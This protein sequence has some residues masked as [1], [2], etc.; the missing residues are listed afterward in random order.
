M[1]SIESSTDVIEPTVSTDLL[2]YSPGDTAVI[3]AE[4]FI[5]GST[6]E[7]QVLHVL[8]PG[9]DGI[10]G[11]S[12]DIIDEETNASGDGHETWTVTDG[13]RTAGE[14]GILGTRDDGGDLDGVADGN[15]TTTWYVNPDDSLDATFLLSA[16]GSGSDGIL[17][18]EDDQLATESFTDSA[19]AYSINFAA[20]DPGD[21]IPDIPYQY[22]LTPIVG[23]GDGDAHIPSAWFNSPLTN[24][25]TKVESLTPK[26]MALGQIVPFEIKI[27]VNGDTSAED[28][29]ITF[30]ASWDITTLGHH[31]NERRRVWIRPRSR[32]LGRLRRYGR[33]RALGFRR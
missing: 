21:Y 10:Y 17:G 7:F 29:V 6:I 1:D 19:G 28:G 8:D 32:R 11:T 14:D 26:E 23:R 27:D 20:A 31:N 9:E 22:N 12:D 4:D 2:D 16:T 13:V 24:T 15:I 5:V 25:D 30:T 33:R 3:T 18:T